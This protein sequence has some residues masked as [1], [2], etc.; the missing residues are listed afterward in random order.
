MLL[1]RQRELRTGEETVTQKKMRVL[2]ANEPRLY[3]EVI[4]ACLRE[5]E[6]E[7]EAVL[8]DPEELDDRVQRDAPDLVFCSRVTP[9][10]ADE[11]PVWAEVYPEDEPL[12]VVSINTGRRRLT[13]VEDNGL[14]NLLWIVEQAKLLFQR[15]G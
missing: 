12:L 14:P 2:V 8:V 15:R 6:P 3:R 10:V 1:D 5:L 4:S 9:R 11:V 13:A 7:I